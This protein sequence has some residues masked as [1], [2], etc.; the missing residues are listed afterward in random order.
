V[1]ESC[2][3]LQFIGCSRSNPVNVDLEAATRAGILVVHT[4]GRNA[5]AAAEF[6]FGLLLSAA[7]NICRGHHALKSGQYLGDNAS[8][9]S[10][11]DEGGDITWE[12]DGPT[13]YLELRGSELYGRT[14]GLVGLGNVG[15][16]VAVLAHAFGMRVLVY[17][18]PRDAAR[19][20]QLGLEFVPF[21]RLLR[22]SDFVSIHCK[23]TDDTCGLFN[24]QA[25]DLMKPSAFL[26]NTAR[27]IV[28][29]HEALIEAL[30]R[31]Q[32]AGAALDVFWY[33]PIPANHPLLQMDNV[34]LTP[35]LGGST[36]DVPPRHSRMLV[37][38]LLGWLDGKRPQHPVNPEIFER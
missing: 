30:A 38:D 32:I 23:V 9:F 29:D 28:V 11:A 15:S 36:Y 21:D 37:D 10:D 16:R 2:P 34:T 14:L 20:A 8:T 3:S 12:L 18:S 25:F 31:K 27:A 4:P 17:S 26:I 22:E 7:R 6:T 35:H 33:E 24:R 5:I 19:A 1:I 13:P